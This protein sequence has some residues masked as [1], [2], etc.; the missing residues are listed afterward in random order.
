MWRYFLKQGRGGLV[1]LAAA[2]VLLCALFALMPL[3]PVY[4]PRPDTAGRLTKKR[5][6]LQWQ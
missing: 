3:D 6:E 4:I 1:C 2:V 5:G